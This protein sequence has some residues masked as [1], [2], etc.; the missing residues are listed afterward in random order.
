MDQQGFNPADAEAKRIADKLMHGRARIAAEKGSSMSSVIVQYLSILPIAIHISKAELESYSLFA[1]YDLIE[2]FAL[3]L[4][5]DLD[6]RTRLA[7]GK[8]DSHPDNWMMNIH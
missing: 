2:R 8:P 4:N 5:W 1:F 6:V 7:G 3:W